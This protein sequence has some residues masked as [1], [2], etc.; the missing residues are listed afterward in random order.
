MKFWQCS[1]NATD[2]PQLDLDL[3][4]LREEA[5]AKVRDPRTI[6]MVEAAH[7]ELKDHFW[8]LVNVLCHWICLALGQQIV[9]K[10]KWQMQVL[11][12]EPNSPWLPINGWNR[13]FCAKRPKHFVGPADS[14]TLFELL[15]GNCEGTG[16]LNEES[17][18][19]VNWRII[20]VAEGSICAH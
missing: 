2:A 10:R 6:K 11:I 3:L 17:S 20:L 5:K 19:I 18:E 9:I 14:W 1:V 7:V 13:K 15:H 16:I 8:T 4:K 12:S